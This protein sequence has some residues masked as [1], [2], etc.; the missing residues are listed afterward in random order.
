MCKPVRGGLHEPQ[1]VNAL[2]YASFSEELC[3]CVTIFSIANSV[4]SKCWDTSDT[5]Y[6]M[7]DTKNSYVLRFVLRNMVFEGN[8]YCINNQYMSKSGRLESPLI[9]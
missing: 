6:P 5:H 1:R 7:L 4:I 8:E 9:N 2:K 3:V